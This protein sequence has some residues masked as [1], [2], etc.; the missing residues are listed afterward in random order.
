MFSLGSFYVLFQFY[1]A[2]WV[3]RSKYN[4]YISLEDRIQVTAWSLTR[5]EPHLGA[6]SLE[7][8]HVV[9]QTYFKPHVDKQNNYKLSEY[10]S[11]W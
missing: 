9:T 3:L 2:N 10:F 4:V 7:K 1:K 8:I 5:W 6:Q 11:L